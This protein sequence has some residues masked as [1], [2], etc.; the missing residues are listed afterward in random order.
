M[1]ICQTTA[2]AVR[3]YERQTM[4]SE[5]LHAG[6]FGR[7]RYTDGVKF[8]AE[9]CGAHWLIDLIESHQA[10]VR[11]KGARSGVGSDFQAWR[12]DLDGKGGCAVR[13]WSDVPGESTKLAAQ[14]I[15]FT[16]WPAELDGYELWLEYGTLMM[17][18]ER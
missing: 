10:S 5:N 9:T 15:P 13:A 17:K 7:I 11:R 18:R 1:T 6:A 4:G 16:D 14:R 8:I 12:I 2:E 3:E